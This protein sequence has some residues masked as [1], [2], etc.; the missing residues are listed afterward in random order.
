MRRFR[1]TIRT[2]AGSTTL[3]ALARSSCELLLGLMDRIPF[4]AVVSVRAL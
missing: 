4:G 3:E 2:Q 1:V